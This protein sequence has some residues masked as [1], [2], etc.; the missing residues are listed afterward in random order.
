MIFVML[1]V[2]GQGLTNHNRMI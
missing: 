2:S 1:S